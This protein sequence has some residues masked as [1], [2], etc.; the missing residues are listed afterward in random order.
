MKPAMSMLSKLYRPSVLPLLVVPLAFC[1][2][3]GNCLGAHRSTGTVRYREWV[4]YRFQYQFDLPVGMIPG[5]EPMNGDGRG[6]T[7]KDGKLTVSVSG[8]NNALFRTV[9]QECAAEVDEYGP[10]AKITYKRVTPKWY[11]LSGTRHGRTFYEKMIYHDEQFDWVLISYPSN[12]ASRFDPVAAHISRSF[13]YV[14]HEW[15][16]DGYH[17]AGTDPLK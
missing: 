10:A 8:Q 15:V 14:P 13:R 5:Q 3:A 6:F 9:A 12:E 2:A 17:L 4:N 11:V 1:W 16:E 7:S